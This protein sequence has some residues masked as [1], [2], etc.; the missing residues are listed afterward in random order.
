MAQEL[1][2]RGHVLQAT[3]IACVRTGIISLPVSVARGMLPPEAA[4]RV[5]RFYLYQGSPSHL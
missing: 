1:D 5:R 2:V 3:A 4:A